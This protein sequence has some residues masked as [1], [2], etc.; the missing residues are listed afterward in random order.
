MDYI[1][2]KANLDDRQAIEQLIMESARNLSREDYSDQQIEAAI[3]TVF[4]V[5]TDLIDSHNILRF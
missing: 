1:I 5:D 4:G 2:R 3:L